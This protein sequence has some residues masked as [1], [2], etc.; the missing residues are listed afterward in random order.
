M[1]HDKIATFWI[2]MTWNILKIWYVRT[3]K[4]Y[5][6]KI[7]RHLDRYFRLGRHRPRVIGLANVRWARTLTEQ[8]RAERELRHHA[9][10]QG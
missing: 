7:R 2:A 3:E 10:T 4:F 9:W 6:E 1:T 5:N 8:L